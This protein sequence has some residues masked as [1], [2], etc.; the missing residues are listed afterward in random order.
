MARQD[1][2]KITVLLKAIHEYKMM[3]HYFNEGKSDYKEMCIKYFA[4]IFC[5]CRN[6]IDVCMNWA[7]K[8][9]ERTDDS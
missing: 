5:I 9:Y 2:T 4:R 6:W 3:G 7:C 1:E 8:K